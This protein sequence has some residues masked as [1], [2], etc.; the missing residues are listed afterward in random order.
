MPQFRSLDRLTI[1]EPCKADWD[2]MSGNEQVRYCEHCSLH[3]NNL[4][5]MTRQQ[6]MRLIA[7]S[8]GRLCV[9][10]I[11]KPDGGVLTGAPQ[12]LYRIGRRI[13]R[14]A[15]GAMTATL[16]LQ[17][18]A[19][20]TRSSSNYQPQIVA[21]S[22]PGSQPGSGATVAGLITDPNGAVV[23]GAKVTLAGKGSPVAFTFP[24]G[25]DGAYRFP[26]LDP[27]IYTLN[28]EGGGF[29]PVEVEV[30]LSRDA[31]KSVSIQ[32]Q[33]QVFVNLVQVESLIEVEN[34]I[35]GGISF[36]TPQEPLVKAAYENDLHAVRELIS[37]SP[38]LNV[39]DKATQMTALEQA[40]ENSNDEVVH[41]LL[42]AGAWTNARSETGTTALMHLREKASAEMV[43]ELISRG[44]LVNERDADGD[45]AL[46]SA[47]A[48]S[49]SLAVKEL[50]MAGARADPKG[51]GGKNALMH[52][53]ANQDPEIVRLLIDAR[54]A[55]DEKDEE[56]KTA[57]MMAAEEGDPENVDI[58]ILAGAQ[59]NQLDN[60][61]WSALMFAARAHDLQS[62]TALLN[63]GADVTLTDKEGKTAL[64]L[65]RVI[66]A[67]QEEIVK[68]L[69]S[70][71]APE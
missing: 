19:A 56:G 31:T 54:A 23:A 26:S 22:Q 45:T 59:I 60:Q 15:A 39:R 25:D 16:S 5:T 44:A 43:R 67:G 53:A 18:A 20:Q 52:A 8:R 27:G 7:R 24:T 30:D 42:L 38:D 58:L 69:K 21:I 32:M 29:A 34:S 35:Q 9:R 48:Y 1:S 62:V 57:L 4:S 71:G 70:R 46:I 3:V 66:E 41:T 63:A 28:V 17:A 50:L 2:S 40:V 11:Q 55:I 68:L 47:S 13:S 36:S 61:G 51:T 10:F 6:A 65:A 14:L 37:T 49:N 33:L 64:S 12:K